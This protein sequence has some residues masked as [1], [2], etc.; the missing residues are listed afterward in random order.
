MPDLRDKYLREDY[1]KRIPGYILTI[2]H[3][4]GR[5]R[6]KSDTNCW[7]EFMA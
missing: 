1:I 5:H 4:W 6:P 7:I 2:Q 3:T